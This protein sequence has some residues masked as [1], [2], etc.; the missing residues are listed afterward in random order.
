MVDVEVDGRVYVYVAWSFAIALSVCLIKPA[1][2]TQ[3]TFQGNNNPA[4]TPVAFAQTVSP[5]LKSVLGVVQ[6]VPSYVLIDSDEDCGTV[7]SGWNSD[8]ASLEVESG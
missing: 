4:G 8:K 6:S 5:R 3:E 1:G 2:S 7:R